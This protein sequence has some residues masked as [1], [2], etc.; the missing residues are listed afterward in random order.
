MHVNPCIITASFDQADV[1]ALQH[2]QLM[3]P[4]AAHPPHSPTGEQLL[5]QCPSSKS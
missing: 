4:A 5:L 1:Q 2:M 3:Q